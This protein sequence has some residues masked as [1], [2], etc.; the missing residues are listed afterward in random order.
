[1]CALINNVQQ[2]F[3]NF[4]HR[5]VNMV[6]TTKGTKGPLLSVLHS[7]YKHK[8]SMALQRAQATYISNR[9]VIVGEGSFRLGVL[10]SLST[11]FFI[12]MLHGTSGGFNT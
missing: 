8:V 12:N 5:C 1:M 11:L 9:V 6:W 10:T 7:F 3:D 2:Q 4:F